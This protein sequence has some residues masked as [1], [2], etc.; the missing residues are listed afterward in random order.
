SW[1]LIIPKGMDY[2][3]GK[4]IKEYLLFHAHYGHIGINKTLA[5]LANEYYWKNMAQDVRE[6]VKSCNIC[7]R[8]KYPTTAPAGLLHPLDIPHRPFSDISM[9]FLYMSKQFLT[10]K[11]PE[12]VY[13]KL[14]VIVCK[15]TKYCFLFPMS[16]KTKVET[17]IHMFTNYVAPFV[18]FPDTIVSD[19]DPLFTSPAWQQFADESQI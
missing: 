11:I 12:I 14:W 7:Q 16:D 13:S 18:G 1:K 5:T 4:P 3:S 15:L 17:L 9:D 2:E 10:P 6:Y 19:R 8:T